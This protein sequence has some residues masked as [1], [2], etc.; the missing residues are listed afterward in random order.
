MTLWILLILLSVL[1]TAGASY[2]VYWAFEKMHEAN[3][4][5]DDRDTLYQQVLTSEKAQSAAEIE[6]DFLKDAWTKLLNNPI[7]AHMSHDQVNAIISFIRGQIEFEKET[8]PILDKKK[9]N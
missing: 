6:R 1:A 7:Q 4:L 9:A 5:R 2:F 3:Y 8:S